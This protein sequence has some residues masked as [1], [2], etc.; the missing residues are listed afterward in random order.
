MPKRKAPGDAQPASD[1]P[2]GEA[3]AASPRRAD[4]AAQAP[5]E[6]AE[7]EEEVQRRRDDEEDDDIMERLARKQRTNSAL[8]E[9][10]MQFIRV[11]TDEQIARFEQ[12]KRSKLPRAAMRRMMQELVGH[13][14][15]KC[16][17]VLSTLAKM[18]V[19]ELTESA[20]EDMTAAGETG[21]IPP[22]RLRLAHQRARQRGTIPPSPKYGGHRFWQTDCGS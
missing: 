3:E 9:W 5:A 12:C 15:E 13:S 14:S 22:S 1:T 7:D 19:G 10:Y 18:F 6:T 11:A 4:E 2:E 21:P 16:A 8:S 20:R 17:I